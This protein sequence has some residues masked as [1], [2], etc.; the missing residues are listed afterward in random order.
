MSD[1][2]ID[3]TCDRRFAA[4]KDA[5]AANFA[6]G[7]D[8]GASVAVVHRGHL[9]VD[10]WGGFVDEER[11]TPWQRD[12]ITNVYSTTKTMSSLAV[13]ILSD[14]GQVDLDAPVATY[15]PEFAA[16]GKEQVLVRHVLGHTAG[17]S[18]WEEKQAPA[19]L[20]DWD[21][22]C[23]KLARQAPWWTPGTASGYH[24]ITQ[25]YLLGE[26]VRRVTGQGFGAWFREEV[27]ESLD[28]DFHI[29]LD[30]AEFGRIAPVIPPPLPKRPEV[31]P[32]ML[33]RTMTNPRLSAEQSWEDGW[34]TAEI[35]AGNGHGNARSVALCQ[36]VVSTPVVEGVSLLS[37]NAANRILETQSDGDDLV[38]GD[39]YRFGMG[40][41]LSSP[42]LALPI[43]DRACFWGGWGGSVVVNDLDRELTV[44]FVMNKMRE[45]TVGD[46]RS[47][48]LVAA[49]QAALD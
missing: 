39:R 7:L 49:A 3:G 16:N 11:T 15:W 18:G 31:M 40:W 13:H 6:S 27:A 19:D 17:L 38:L 24:A 32:P 4:L 21:A 34:R 2:P 8:V 12:T 41:A 45:T 36:A 9:V 42:G 14:R 30:P 29:G 46:Q 47:A 37:R 22:S 26:I 25:G 5:F 23:A 48:T 20:Y 43:G 35:P 44:A 28:A 10:L 1:T 33:V